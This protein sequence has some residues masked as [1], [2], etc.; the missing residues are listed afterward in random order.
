[1]CTPKIRKSCPDPKFAVQTFFIPSESYSL[2]YLRSKLCVI[3]AKG[4]EIMNLDSLLPGT[5]PDF[6][7]CPRD[8]VQIQML[9]KRIEVAKALGMFK[10]SESEFLLCYDSESDEP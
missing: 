2:Q 3:C 1:M 9:M 7:Q 6:S 4:F 5:I 10:I 8:D